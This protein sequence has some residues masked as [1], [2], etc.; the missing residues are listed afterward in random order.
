MINIADR[1]KNLPPYPFADLER[2]LRELK[3]QGKDITRLDIGSP[4]LPP[5]DF[6]IEAMYRSAQDASH[7]GYAGYYGTP[8]FRR[9]VAVYYERRFGVRLG[10]D[11]QVVALIGSKEGIANAAPAFVNPGQAVLVPD[12]GYPTY[13]LGTLL[14]GGRPGPVPLYE[15]DQFLPDLEAIPAEGARS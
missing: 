15:H 1:V 8:E 12:P 11:K 3:A 9:A 7:H 4:D 5:P 10:P 13:T 2:R 6:I 14:A